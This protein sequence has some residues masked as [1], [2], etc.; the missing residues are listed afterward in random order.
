MIII[1]SSHK[2]LIKLDYNVWLYYI[3]L[4]FYIS[5]LDSSA[6]QAFFLTTIIAIASM[7]SLYKLTLWAQRAF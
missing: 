4:H 2:L 7:I 6:K 1:M 3:Y 5:L